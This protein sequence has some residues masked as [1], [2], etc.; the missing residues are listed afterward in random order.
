MTYRER[1]ALAKRELRKRKRDEQIR[2]ELAAQTRDE[3]ASDD[4]DSESTVPA[5]ARTHIRHPLRHDSALLRAKAPRLWQARHPLC[6]HHRALRRAHTDRGVL[7]GEEHAEPLRGI[8]SCAHT[9]R[10]CGGERWRE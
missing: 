7:H 10:A 6:H 4:D 9:T 1:R 8:C 2:A 5:T 3:Q